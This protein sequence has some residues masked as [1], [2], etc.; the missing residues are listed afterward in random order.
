MLLYFLKTQ[1]TDLQLQQVWYL[2][3]VY[4]I[5]QPVNVSCTICGQSEPLGPKLQA[6]FSCL[7][8]NEKMLGFHH[9]FDYIIKHTLYWIPDKS[10]IRPQIPSKASTSRIKCP[11]PIPPN[12]GL[13]D[14]SP[15]KT[16]L[17]INDTTLQ[18]RKRVPTYCF[19]FVS[20]K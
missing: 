17:R 2:N 6:L 1:E 12:E 19:N 14:I 9:Y 10:H 13:Q 11:L 4:W 5:I 7:R 3:W 16:I 15:I 8:P 18:Y 20:E